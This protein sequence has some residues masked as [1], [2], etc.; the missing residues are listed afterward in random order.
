MPNQPQTSQSDTNYSNI[1]SDTNYSNIQSDTN[2]SNIQSD[3]NYSN[4]QSH[5]NDSDTS[6]DSLNGGQLPR[7]TESCVIEQNYIDPDI[8][9]EQL[10]RSEP[11][12][13]LH[14]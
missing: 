6:D 11:F 5:T 7:F 2:F 1:Q 3:T 4:I 12:T 9:I 13:S 14:C 8:P 10:F